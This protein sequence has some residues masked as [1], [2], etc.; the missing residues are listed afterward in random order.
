M[1]GSAHQSF[2]DNLLYVVV[3]FV[4]CWEAQRTKMSKMPLVVHKGSR[5]KENPDSGARQPQYESQ[6][7]FLLSLYPQKTFQ[8]CLCLCFDT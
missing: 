2:L 8:V 3:V 5:V 6:V 7:C 4:G 1:P